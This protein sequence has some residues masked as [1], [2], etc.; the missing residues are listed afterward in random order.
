MHILAA[1]L[2]KRNPV[3]NNNC[4]LTYSQSSLHS[5]SSALYCL[6]P[7]GQ[8]I[9]HVTVI[10]ALLKINSG[11]PCRMI[12]QVNPDVLGVFFLGIVGSFNC[13]L[14]RGQRAP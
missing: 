2:V 8:V 3:C 12:C 11:G 4:H 1:K 5:K 9:R 10:D 7:P 14:W 13:A 6:S